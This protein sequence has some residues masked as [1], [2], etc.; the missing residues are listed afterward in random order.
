MFGFNA[1]VPVLLSGCMKTSEVVHQKAIVEARQTLTADAPLQGVAMAKNAPIF[2]V[3]G[4]LYREDG[5]QLEIVH[6]TR[7]RVV[8]ATD[9]GPVELRR[10]RLERDGYDIA[11]GCVYSTTR[12]RALQEIAS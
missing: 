10:A 8:V 12:Y 1:G 11:D 5:R 3:S 6:H 7:R 2:T 9:H 4:W